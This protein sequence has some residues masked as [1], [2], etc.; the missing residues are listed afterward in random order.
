[1]QLTTLKRHRKFQMNPSKYN[2]KFGKLARQTDWQT[3]GHTE[4]EETYSPLGFRN[5][6]GI[7]ETLIQYIIYKG[8]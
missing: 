2:G 7:N 3:D 1:M 4:R 5:Q 6:L 8:V